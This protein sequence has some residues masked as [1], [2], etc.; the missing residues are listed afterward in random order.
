MV[1]LPREPKI[2]GASPF[3]EV[4]LF[5]QLIGGDDILP[6]VDRPPMLT[7]PE[8]VKAAPNAITDWFAEYDT[9]SAALHLFST[10]TSDRRMYINVRFLLAAQS[11]E[12]F[13]RE[14]YPSTIVSDEEHAAIVI[15]LMAAIPRD[16]AKEMRE[17][18][19]PSYS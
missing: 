2:E 13:H 6:P 4:E 15:A 17:K 3:A 7:A 18:L 5:A 8:L 9:L 19:S 16:A 14:A 1:E 11:V 10:I 12:T